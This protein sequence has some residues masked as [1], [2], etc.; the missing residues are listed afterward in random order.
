MPC[1]CECGHEHHTDFDTH[2]NI[3]AF[4][5]GFLHRLWKIIQEKTLRAEN[6]QD[7]R[8]V[9]TVTTRSGTSKKQQK[10]KAE[11][12]RSASTEELQQPK[13]I[14][15]GS[16]ERP[17]NDR[18]IVTATGR[19]EIKNGIGELTEVEKKPI[20]DLITHQASTQE[21]RVRP[22]LDRFKV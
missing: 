20:I 14:I 1:A 21:I 19:D 10:A 7:Q 4:S 9:N 17:A 16:Q 11:P 15:S 18:F 22:R 12:S 6:T 5:D 2:T 13:D 8:Q 3:D